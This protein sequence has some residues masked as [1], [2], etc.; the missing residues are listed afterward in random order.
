[1]QAATPP[2]YEFIAI[3]LGP[4]NL[5]LA[6]LMSPLREH[7]CLFLEQNTGFHWHPGMLVD[8]A[9]LQNPFLADLVTLADPTSRFSYLNHCRETG[10]L[11]RFFI[12]ENFTLT[13]REYN[14][15][16]QWALAQLKNVRLGARVTGLVHDPQHG[17]YRVGG[18]DVASG[19]PFELR[20]RKLVLG[21][22]SAPQLPPGCDTSPGGIHSSAYLQH[23]PRLQACRSVTVVGSGQSA[24]EIVHDL[25]K[26]GERHGH[27][28]NWITRSPRFFPM[29]YA[30]LTL[31]LSTPDYADHF[32]GLAPQRKQQ[33]LREQRNVYNGINRSLV[34]RI[35]DL[36]D[37]RCAAGTPPGRLL[38]HCELQSCRFDAASGEHELRFFHVDQQRHYQH[39]TDGLVFATGYAHRVPSFVEGIRDRILWDAQGRYRQAR[40]YS[41]DIE[42]REVF[43]Q[44]AGLHD[45]G[46][47]APDL[48]MSCLRNARLIRELTGVEYYPV[49]QRIAL[50]DFVPPAGGPLV[51][52]TP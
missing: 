16:G 15:Y 14:R 5:S 39:R 13:R 42:G 18:H 6:C 36:L 37:E 24:A 47:T 17:E 34:D 45:H 32:F 30:K 25:L 2:P 49:E 46:L 10:R 22:G 40:N 23:K 19:R 12:R 27:A 9:T 4:F 43:V 50:Q 33:V 48:G 31:E 38:T 26:D 3:G 44:N 20:G 52:V 41:V 1:M 21:I 7:R 51:P 8:G 35:Y 29:E 11:Y 28:L